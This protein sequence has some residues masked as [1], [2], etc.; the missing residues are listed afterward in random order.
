MKIIKKISDNHYLVYEEG[1]LPD[2]FFG[3][4]KYAF[5]VIIRVVFLLAIFFGGMAILA[6]LINLFN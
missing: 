4:I 1:D 2:T 5:N 3:I 6:F